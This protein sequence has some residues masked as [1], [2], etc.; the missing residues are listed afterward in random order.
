LCLT[1]D[2][3]GGGF[4]GTGE[5]GRIYRVSRNGDVEL[6]A[7]LDQ[8]HVSGLHPAG[9]TVFV[10]T[11]NPAAALRAR[12]DRIEGGTFESAP[13]DAGSTARWGAFRWRVEGEGARPEFH[14]RTGASPE[15]DETWSAWSPVL[16]EAGAGPVRNP[17]GRYLQWRVN[18]PGGAYRV[19][20]VEVVS[21]P[22]NRPPQVRGFRA[23]DGPAFRDRVELRW[24]VRD[25]DGDPV[26]VRIRVRRPGGEWTEVALAPSGAESTSAGPASGSS[27]RAGRGVW[28][29]ADAPEGSYDVE[30]IGSDRASNDPRSGRETPA[31]TV[32]RLT[33]D[34]TPPAVDLS[35]ASEGTV[36]ATVSDALSGVARL[37]LR[38]DGVVRA[39]LR[40]RDGLCDSDRET[41]LVEIPEGPGA[42]SLRGADA[43]GN[44]TDVPVPGR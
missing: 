10:G 34:R 11:S 21:E 1:G 41:F 14:T 25:A 31:D 44:T 9:R 13:L 5:P 7:T 35:T 40:P 20:G 39:T 29:A 4:F 27:W 12:P 22:Y 3:N 38:V 30:A 42:V 6:L 28:E 43:A 33:V 18:L 19:S 17:D 23:A 2:G 15:P 24:E 26:D 36:E 32:L 37:E 8:G 16:A